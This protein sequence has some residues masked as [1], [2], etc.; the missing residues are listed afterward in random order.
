MTVEELV[1]HLSQALATGVW[2]SAVGYGNALLRDYGDRPEIV[3]LIQRVQLTLLRCHLYLGQWAE[4]APLFEV[5][6]QTLSTAPPAARGELL[7]QKAACELRLEQAASA[8]K[9]IAACLLLLPPTSPLRPEAVLLEA[10]CLTASG[11]PLEAGEL[12]TA[13]LSVLDRSQAE[14]AI[15]LGMRAFL[16]AKQPGRAHA[17]LSDGARKFPGIEEEVGLQSLLLQAGSDLLEQGSPV[18]AL[19]CLKRISP[20]QRLILVQQQRLVTMEKAIAAQK[21]QP[22]SSLPLGVGLRSA[23]ARVRTELDSLGGGN[24]FAAA[25]RIQIAAAYHALQRPHEAA[26]VLEDAVHQLPPAE[27]LEHASLELAKTWLQLERWQKVIATSAQF[28]SVYPASKHLALMLYLRGCAEQKAGLFAEALHSFTSLTVDFK[29]H[30]LC[31]S[32]R[33]M[34]PFTLLLDNRPAEAVKGFAVFVQ[35]HKKHDLA[36]AAAYW[37]CVAHAQFSPPASVRAAASAYL[38]GFPNGENR[39][40]ALLRRAQ[41]LSA[42]REKESAVAD[43]ETL[44]SEAP[45][46]SCSGEAALLLGDC[47]LAQGNVGGALAAWERV[48]PNQREARE[49]AL[50]KCVKILHRDRRT[51]NV[52]ELL[53]AFD[54]AHA[55]SSRLAEA[56][57]WLWKGVLS[58]GTRGRG[59]RLDH[60]TRRAVWKQPR[61]HRDRTT[62]MRRLNSSRL[63]S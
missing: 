43:L 50:F 35:T 21:A 44:L 32:A 11:T 6:L 34:Q 54:S 16:E 2:E 62:A 33:F 36:E 59:N 9:S 29:N 15:R 57:H 7:F 61:R 51:H 55:D 19:A 60:P 8:S 31:A 46:H 49:E 30:E 17:L 47:L 48:P 25:T 28:A 56:A 18:A 63:R 58:R 42:L 38:A 53:R 37:L 39:P 20:P 23:A 10:T 45:E 52:R 41:A 27:L 4:S 3:P 26:L 40:A 1:H 22:G 14:R 5:A 24:A 12:L 13:S